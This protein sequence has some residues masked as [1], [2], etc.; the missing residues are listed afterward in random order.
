MR[1]ILTGLLIS[2]AFLSYSQWNTT[3]SNIHFTGGMVGIGTTQPNTALTV[4]TDG[5]VVTRFIST[6]LGGLSGVRLQG[7]NNDGTDVRYFDIAFD[8]ETYSYGFGAGSYSSALPISSGLA[9]ADIVVDGSGNVGIGTTIPS[10]KLEIKSTSSNDAELHINTNNDGQQSIIRFQDQGTSTWGFLSNYPNAGKFSLYN[11]QNSSNAMVLDVEGN[12]GIGTTS[13]TEKLQVNGNIKLNNG[14]KL[15]QSS[16]GVYNE[17]ITAS[18]GKGGGLM[19][20]AIYAGSGN[21]QDNA[22][23]AINPGG[24]GASAG[25]ID[26]DGNAKRWSFFNSIASTAIGDPVAFKPIAIFDDSFISLSP[27][28]D[29]SQFHI[30]SSGLVGIGTAT[31]DSKLTVKGKIHAEEVK[32]D[33][34]VP[35]PDYVFEPDYDLLTL[36]ETAAYIQTNKHLPEIPSA[37]E[38]EANGV[39]LGEMNMLLLKKIEELTLH[40]IEQQKQLNRQT[41]LEEKLEEMMKIIQ[42]QQQEIE[43]LKSKLK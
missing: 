36:E 30:L 37:K 40:T 43:N 32:V 21:P 16:N 10:A 23:Y 42:S 15:I 24:Y 2:L 20:N 22:V 17:L 14:S 25:Y 8:P 18:H 35:G 7:K 19:V 6:K 13:P 9:K 1:N 31:P 3:G 4:S 38:M 12:V 41:K 26:Y 29:G 39:Q 34:S 11:Y 27:I 28:G 33:L 5:S